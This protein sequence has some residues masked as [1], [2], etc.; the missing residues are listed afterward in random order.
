MK[1]DYEETEF[2][3]LYTQIRGLPKE[4]LEEPYCIEILGE[5]Y[6]RGYDLRTLNLP[7]DPDEEDEFFKYIEENYGT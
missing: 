5:M 6:K 3:D 2:Y 7:L 1:T 4:T